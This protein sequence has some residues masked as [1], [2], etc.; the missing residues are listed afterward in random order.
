MLVNTEEFYFSFQDE[1]FSY[2]GD[3]KIS[4]KSG[5]DFFSGRNAGSRNFSGRRYKKISQN[6]FA[7]KSAQALN[8]SSTEGLI[9]Y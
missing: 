2:L 6:I 8:Y 5:S 1:S 9:G 4:S 7:K 3:F